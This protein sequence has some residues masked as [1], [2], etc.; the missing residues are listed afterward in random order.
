[1]FIK[2]S[3]YPFPKTYIHYNCDCENTGIVAERQAAISITRGRK[4]LMWMTEE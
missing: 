2:Q 4:P 1:M 3:E